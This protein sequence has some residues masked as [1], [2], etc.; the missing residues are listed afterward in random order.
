MA[1]ITDPAALAE[2]EV[3]AA[4]PEVVAAPAPEVEQ[5]AAE[6]DAVVP[7]AVPVPTAVEDILH[8]WVY[9]YLANS[10]ISRNPQSWE[11]LQSA[12]PALAALLKKG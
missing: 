2:P 5:A 1:E 10:P 8:A 3:V 7:D 11:T 6:P 12:L 9:T 4:E